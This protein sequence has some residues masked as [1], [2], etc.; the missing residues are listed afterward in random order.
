MRNRLLILGLLALVPAQVM[1]AA[2]PPAVTEKESKPAAKPAEKPAEKPV[3]RVVI[4]AP[5]EGGYEIDFDITETPELKE[6]VTTKLQPACVE[7]YPKIV[8]M[9][10]SEGYEAPKKF[11][12][13]FRRNGRG[14]AAT[15]GTRVFCDY[16][17]FSKN[18]EG[19]AV[20]AVIHELVHVVQQYGRAR[21]NANANGG[22]PVNRNPGWLVEGLSDYI[23]WFLYE[24][25]SARPKPRADRANYNDSYRTTGHF[26]NYVLNKYDK[27]VVK[28]LNAAMREGKYS[29]E[30][31][32]QSTGK[33]LEELGKEWKE[34]LPKGERKPDAP[35]PK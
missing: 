32:K 25:E 21:A 13:I 26:L 4:V 23:R 22:G 27:D 12:V 19:E 30:L 31:W 34:T 20:G 6:W 33:T 35:A 9:L 7:W 14:V 3:E 16:P 29:D 8:A 1:P 28:K 24:P 5:V 18:L 10:P 17:W 2:D 15:G 11:P